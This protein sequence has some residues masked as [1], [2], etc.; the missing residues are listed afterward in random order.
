[1]R[2]GVGLLLAP[3]VQQVIKSYLKIGMVGNVKRGCS[4]GA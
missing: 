1:M 4:A 3:L 2:F